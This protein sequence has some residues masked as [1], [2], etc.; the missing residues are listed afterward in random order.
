MT[1]LQLKDYYEDLFTKESLQQIRTAS[2]R[3]LKDTKSR[4]LEIRNAGQWDALKIQKYNRLKSLEKDLNKILNNMKT[5]QFQTIRTANVRLYQEIFNVSKFDAFN[6][7]NLPIQFAKIDR[8][9]ALKAITNPIPK[10]NLTEIAARQRQEIVYA[11]QQKLA[12]QII[13]GASYRETA[14]LVA[15][16]FN[17]DLNR[18]EMVVW[19]ENHRVK[20]LAS[21]DSIQDTAERYKIDIWKIWVATADERT[22]DD[23]VEADAQR[24][25]YDEMFE[26]GNS[27]GLAPGNMMGADSAAQN[28]RCRCTMQEVFSKD[29]DPNYNTSRVDYLK[30]KKAVTGKR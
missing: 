10:L 14:E 13:S 16:I 21:L 26:V 22:R 30:W 23:H 9:A 27:R 11:L 20:E 29:A 17:N 7:T 19:T 1:I 3:A 25:K 2:A 5:A 18:A 6:Q 24:V 4:M 8:D 15:G 12:E 28:I